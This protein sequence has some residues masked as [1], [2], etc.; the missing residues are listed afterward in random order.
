L[1]LNS[2]TAESLGLSERIESMIMNK[3]AKLQKALFLLSFLFCLSG[4]AAGQSIEDATL[5]LGRGDFDAALEIVRTLA[6]QGSD[7][8]QYLMGYLL[9]QDE[10]L[11]DDPS[12]AAEWFLKAANQGHVRAQYDLGMLYSG[13]GGIKKDMPRAIEWLR[14]AAEQGDGYASN[15]L[16][17]LLLEGTPTNSDITEAM[18]FFKRAAAQ[19]DG[20]HPETSLGWHYFTGKF[21][22]MIP[23]DYKESLRWNRAG[24]LKG[25]ANAHSNIALHYFTG[26]GVEQNY[27]EMVRYLVRS[28]DS[29]DSSLS[30]VTENNQD[31]WEEFRHLAPEKFWRAREVYWES[32]KSANDV[33]LDALLPFLDSQ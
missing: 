21:A 27:S 6:D 26:F 30:W 5:A 3:H 2:L 33:S 19:L 7:R 23:Q 28:A 20:G 12:Q 1:N 16:A 8:A 17:R 15:N 25:H 9:T 4:K 14:R 29:F 10:N 32:I 18:G 13:G 24:A 11:A 22:P 31:E